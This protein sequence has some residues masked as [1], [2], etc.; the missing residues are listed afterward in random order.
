MDFTIHFGIVLVCLSFLINYFFSSVIPKLT[1]LVYTIDDTVCT[2]ILHPGNSGFQNDFFRVT[3]EIIA[4]KNLHPPPPKKDMLLEIK[5]V[6][7]EK[8]IHPTKDCLV[9]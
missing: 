5:S 8:G 2:F 6:K 9:W 3:W 1:I 7:K 4:Q